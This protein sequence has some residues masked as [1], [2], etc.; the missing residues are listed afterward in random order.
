MFSS[1]RLVATLVLVSSLVSRTSAAE[2]SVVRHS[3]RP[4]APEVENLRHKI[5]AASKT[6]IRLTGDDMLGRVISIHDANIP[7]SSESAQ[8]ITAF[9]S[10]YGDLF[11]LAATAEVR[12]IPGAT[13]S[14]RVTADVYFAG[15][16]VEDVLA[17]ARFDGGALTFASLRAPRSFAIQGAFVIDHSVAIAAAKHA[18]STRRASFGKTGALQPPIVEAVWLRDEAGLRAAIRTDF[19]SVRPGEAWRVHVDASAGSVIR[20]QDRVRH[21]TKGFYP[22]DF[23]GSFITFQKFPLGEAKGFVFV[24]EDDAVDGT[25]DQKKIKNFAVKGVPALDID[26]GF[27]T[28][29]IANVFD[30]YGAD[31]FEPTMFFGYDPFET[32]TLENGIPLYD[33][34]DCFNVEYQLERFYA[35]LLKSLGKSQLGSNLSMPVIVNSPETQIN[36]FFSPTPFPDAIDPQTFGYLEFFDLTESTFDMADDIARDPVVCCHE[37]THAWLFYENLPFDDELDFPPRAVGEA[38]PDFFATT[39]HKTNQVGRYTAVEMNG[40]VPIRQL[41]DDDHFPET[42]NESLYDQD[43]GAP[44]VILPEE[45]KNG[46]IFGSFLLD[47]RDHLGDKRAEQL[48]FKS[49]ASMPHT[50]ADVGFSSGQVLANPLSATQEF[51]FES[52]FAMLVEAKDSVESGILYGAGLGRGIFQN[53]GEYSLLLILENA[54]DRKMVLPT[55]FPRA[56]GEAKFSFHAKQGRKL[57]VIVSADPASTLLPSFTLSTSNLDPG[58]FT[59]NSAMTTSPNGKILTQSN[60]VLNLPLGAQP[61]TGDPSYILTVNA[62]SGLGYYTVTLDV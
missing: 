44:V 62:S 30:F 1:R 46:E 21:Q 14:D 11:G 15:R 27:I 7:G 52:A 4:L 9:F 28:G 18:L 26:K 49:M 20:I 38:I 42:T 6:P 47:A 51:F 8:A 23:D 25:F 45:H 19:Y 39:L 12:A 17:R 53:S 5:V 56:T 55:V 2:S 33:A 40:G 31:P 48:V 37:Y 58:A 57:K 50:M 36:A 32:E 29:R 10:E 43:P 22:F 59:F 41:Q 60:I 3:P 35:H 54:T 16:R 61:G 24:N 34:F 13:F